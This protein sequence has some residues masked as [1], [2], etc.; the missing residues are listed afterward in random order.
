MGRRT[1]SRWAALLARIYEVLPLL[2][3]EGFIMRTPRGWWGRAARHSYD[4]DLARGH[5]VHRDPVDRARGFDGVG[6]RVTG[7]GG[8]SAAAHGRGQ[9]TCKVTVSDHSI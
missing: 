5:S 7:V 6:S 4:H 8:D 2:I 1:A 3:Q 9:L